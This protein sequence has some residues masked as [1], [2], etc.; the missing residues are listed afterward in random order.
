MQKYTFSSEIIRKCMIFSRKLNLFF[1][2]VVSTFYS[3]VLVRHQFPYTC[4]VIGAKQV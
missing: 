1:A 2:K 4:V 3:S